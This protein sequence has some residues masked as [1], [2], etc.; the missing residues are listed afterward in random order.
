MWRIEYTYDKRRQTTGVVD[1]SVLAI[2][3]NDSSPAKHLSG[4]NVCI[5]FGKASE[6][7]YD[8]LCE[9]IADGLVTV[10]VQKD[11]W[12]IPVEIHGGNGW[13]DSARYGYDQE[14]SCLF[15]Y[16]HPNIFNTKVC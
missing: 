1:V 7:D 12:R 2:V 9:K 14:A 10:I 8:N 6:K 15:G 16:I 5:V 4:L 13:S 3:S 11:D